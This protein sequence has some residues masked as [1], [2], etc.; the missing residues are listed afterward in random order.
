MG[1][2]P[3]LGTEEKDAAGAAGGGPGVG[4]GGFDA[5]GRG[6]VELLAPGGMPSLAATG[7]SHHP[8]VGN[9]TSRCNGSGS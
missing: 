8:D 4:G 6:S 2:V 7:L 3:E 9:N 5:A 1:G